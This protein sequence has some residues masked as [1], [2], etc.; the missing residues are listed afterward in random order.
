MNKNYR[1]EYLF[2]E[3]YL[4]DITQ[5]PIVDENLKNSFRTIKGWRDEA[6]NTLPESWITT[7]I[8]NI[9]D[10]LKFGHKR[11]PEKEANILMLFPDID[12][13]KAMS[14]C[15]IIPPEEDINCTLKGKFWAEKIIRNLRK[16]NF[17]WGIL[18]DGYYWRIYHV[19]EPN[20]YETYV[21]INLET[22]LNDQDYTAFQIFY[23]F[24]RPDNFIN[25][26][27]GECNFDIYKD[28]SEKTTKYIE[29]N[30]RAAIE[31]EGEGKGVLQTLCSG[32][33][34]TLN[35][36]NYSE[37]DNKDIYDG[38]IIYLFRLLFLFYSTSRDLLKRE[39]IEKFQNIIQDSFRFCNEG[40]LKN[41][42]YNLW[43]RLQG[44]Y[45]EINE[46]Y[47]GGLFNYYE[48]DFTKFIE[49]IKITDPFLS[50][51]IFGLAYYQ[52][53]K[54]SFVPIEYRDLSVRHLG[55]LYEGLLEHNL[56]VASENM[57]IRKSGSKIRYI[58]ESKAGKITR[59]DTILPKGEI[60]FSEDKNERKLSGSYYT[61][62]DVVEYIVKNTVD[63][64]LEEKEKEIIEEIT[65]FINDMD[66]AVNE[67][68][69]NRFEQYIDDRIYKFVEEK[70][71]ALSV[72]DPTMGSGHFLVNATNHITNFIVKLLNEYPG[73][74]SKIDS[75]PK[76]WRRKVVENCIFGVDLNPRAVELA[77]LCLWIA[78]T[79]KEKPLSFLNHHLK[80][81][82]A[83]VGV[84]I[85]DLEKHLIKTGVSDNNL[86]MQPYIDSIKQ[87]A[88]YYKK[89]LSKF[90]DTI[91][92]IEE[93]KEILE[94][95]NGE[96]V[97]YKNLCDVF[98]FYL[99]GKINES[100]FLSK[101]K[102]WNAQKISQKV[103]SISGNDDFFHWEIEFPDVLYG[104]N[105]GFDCVIG[106]PPYIQHQST[107]YKPLI[108]KTKKC[109]NTYAFILEKSLNLLTYKGTYGF[110]IPMSSIC[111]ERMLL[112]QNVLNSQSSKIKIANFADRPSKIFSGVE[113]KVSMIHGEKKDKNKVP[114]KTFS[115]GYIQWNAE[116]RKILF[117]EN[118]KKIYY[119]YCEEFIKPGSIPKL[120]NNVEK[121]ILKKISLMPHRIREITTNNENSR[122]YI[123]YHTIGRYWLTT[124]DF[125]P[126]YY[127][128]GVKGISSD[129][130]IL[131]LKYDN[132]KDFIILLLNSSLFYCYWIIYSDCF[133]LTKKFIEDFPIPFKDILDNSYGDITNKLC[134]ILMLDYQKH[135]ILQESTYSTGRIT[136]Q[137][138]FPG[139]SK[140][141]IDK[142]DIALGELYGFDKQEI[143]YIINYNI[144]FR[145]NKD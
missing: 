99:L 38:A 138:F 142:I 4:Q 93:K 27:S 35:Q 80:K 6:D 7:Y 22:I 84:R 140:S 51:V 55:S 96:L 1:N 62:E 132:I 81:G 20:P 72:L 3:T 125:I 16:N 14:L 23:F 126:P 12:K 2:S 127:R 37:K 66:I 113:Q 29:E 76:I 95:V 112:L 48:S 39:S 49:E 115:S 101:I 97:P 26:K 73:S 109:G 21:E 30:L 69:R 141:I 107:T 59:S 134:K 106:N 33:L 28:K 117:N 89:K 31:R 145:I 65:P 9:F 50:E 135:S 40:G 43:N 120:Y 47:N 53:S 45:V 143:D 77:K 11:N 118:N 13:I 90:T 57:V 130:K 98:T 124:F 17:Q 92:D 34:N 133:H 42:S 128:N 78:T 36:K 102:N 137:T 18:T 56:F 87:A 70:I 136:H 108:R 104:D 71:L 82:N 54:G 123:C 15:Y 32:Y 19:T 91:E 111:T 103:P 24:F 61:P 139:K 10:T 58:P 105:S 46:K 83:L 8:E 144:D 86:F 94:E 74:N 68:E 79:F 67:S 25:N 41:D 60:Y 44:L 52:K 64:L 116:D 85:S 119:T 88:E 121:N 114:C 63:F 122:S 129:Y 75:D 100:E 131:S 110:I 5:L